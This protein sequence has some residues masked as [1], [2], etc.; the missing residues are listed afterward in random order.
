MTGHTI[1]DGL[2][3]GGLTLLSGIHCIGV[4]VLAMS[5]LGYVV[6]GANWVVLWY[7]SEAGHWV[8]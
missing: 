6:Y 8:C 5:T 1:A 7:L 2:L 3:C 4:L